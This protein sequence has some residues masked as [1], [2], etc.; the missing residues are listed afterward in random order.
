MRITI[1]FIFF[2]LISAASYSQTKYFYGKLIDS[3]TLLPV[4]DV[5]VINN[6]TRAGDIT[7]GKGLFVIQGSLN[8]TLTFVKVGYWQKRFALN[9]N[10]AAR[11]TF[12][13]FFI[14]KVH[15]LKSVLVSS[16]SYADYQQD[17][18]ERRNNFADIV[19][20]SHHLVE[21]SNSG[22][23]I[24]F[25]LDRIF[26]RKEKKKRRALKFF[27]ENEEEQYVKFRFNSILI[28]S[29]TGYK[30]KELETFITRYLPTY[31]WLR[32][33]NSDDD[34]LYYVNDKLKDYKEHH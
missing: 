24:G 30:G 7:N 3:L 6:N 25:S 8:D 10:L 26:S 20:Y 2:L 28:H 33:H 4:E 22:A 13:I 12:T 29:L 27:E 11:D 32:T 18:I 1:L 17:S 14:P 16:Y 15:E 9:G 23:G 21:S 34:L 5:H 31:K 19:G